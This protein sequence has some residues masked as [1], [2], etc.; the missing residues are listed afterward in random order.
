M[1]GGE[2]MADF[3]VTE[4]Q[5]E[6]IPGMHD[7]FEA[8]IP[9]AFAADG[10]E[11]FEEEIA[12]EITDK[13]NKVARSLEPNS[14]TRFWVAKTGDKVIGT[15]SFGPCGTHVRNVTGGKFD[16]VG[17]LGSIYVD[18][19]THGAGVGSALIN[20]VMRYLHDSGITE[21]CLDSGY[22]KAQGQWR[23]KFGEP[24]AIAENYWNS[25]NDHWV[26]YC[27]VADH[28]PVD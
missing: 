12:S 2:A 20:T 11:G 4:P 17:E 19:D 9:Y 1:K 23:R 15:V 24:Y 6:D 3:I 14:A 25:G 26:W 27:K 5:P 13:T 18:P 10:L 16:H 21:F 28:Y 8:A 22:Q 7:V